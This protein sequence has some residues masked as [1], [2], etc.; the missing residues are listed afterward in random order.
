MN[1]HKKE[2]SV[3]GSY[4]MHSDGAMLY[5]FWYFLKLF[6]FSFQTSSE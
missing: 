1:P 5:F 2:A 6:T 3:H 4:R